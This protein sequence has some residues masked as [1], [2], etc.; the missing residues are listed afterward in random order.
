[1]VP[2]VRLSRVIQAMEQLS[3]EMV[4]EEVAPV[5]GYTEA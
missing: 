4:G 5:A 3:L 1:V 2:L